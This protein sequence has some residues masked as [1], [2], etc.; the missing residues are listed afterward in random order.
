[1]SVAKFQQV[2]QANVDEALRDLHSRGVEAVGCAAH[3]GSLPDLQRLA[4]LARDTYGRV[5]VLVSNAAVNP[6]AGLILDMPDSAIDKIL[7]I[8]IKAAITLTREVR[9]LMPEVRNAAA[10]LQRKSHKVKR[11]NKLYLGPSCLAT[12]KRAWWSQSQFPVAY[13]YTPPGSLV[14]GR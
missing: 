4:H 13:A 8:N 2:A 7:D 5:D 1:M 6:A 14:R 11:V 3:V 12:C 9:P 10:V